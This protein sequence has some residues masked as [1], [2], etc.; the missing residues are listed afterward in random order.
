VP[1]TNRPPTLARCTAAI[2]ASDEPPDELIVVEEPAGAGPAAARNA[3]A[4]SARGDLLVFV[5]AD[6]VLHPTALGL[7]RSRL[8]GD[9]GLAGVFG[10]Y[11][12]RPDGGT[13][14]VFRNLLHHHVHHASAG[15]AETFWAGIGAI[16]RDVFLEIGGF[17]EERYPRP[18]VEDIELGTRLSASGARLLLDP[19]IQGTH[20]KRWTLATMV[21]TDLFDRGVPWTLLMLERGR[22]GSGLNLGWRHRA[23]ALASVAV[24][25][26]IATGRPRAAALPTVTLVALNGRFYRLLARRAGSRAAV[27]GV[28]LHVVHHATGVL[29]AGLGVARYVRERRRRA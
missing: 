25:G 11:D 18:S 13:V 22:I 20:L 19:A 1:A 23:S 15:E 21:R 7:I 29:A 28:G 2:L 12:E 26:A 14:S 17:D 6:I 24:I 4:R 27:A 5:D 8:E 9:P 16:R 3:G 10:S